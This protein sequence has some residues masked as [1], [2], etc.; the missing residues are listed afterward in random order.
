MTHFISLPFTEQLRMRSCALGFVLCL[1]LALANAN[2][3]LDAFESSMALQQSYEEETEYFRQRLGWQADDYAY[4]FTNSVRYALETA[5]TEAQG[6]ALQACA[7]E[8]AAKSLEAIS[9]F[10]DSLQSVQNEANDLHFSVFR[11]L[12]ETNIKAEDLELFYYYHSYRVAAAFDRLW[13]VH[14]VVL[15]DHWAN[16]WFDYFDISEELYTCIESAL[17]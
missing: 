16:M 6:A 1:C 15:G 3:L 7:G 8:A 17:A 2:Y 10:D 9:A 4:Y 5:T 13:D 14:V 11:Q 12:M